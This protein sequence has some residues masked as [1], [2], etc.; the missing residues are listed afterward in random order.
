MHPFLCIQ[1][2]SISNRKMQLLF[3]EQLIRLQISLF[4]HL[5]NSLQYEYVELLRDMQPL[6]CNDQTCFAYY[7]A[8]GLSI[9][10]LFR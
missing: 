3:N 6:A 8:V 7:R 2:N 5:P 10:P 9:L 1:K 4:F